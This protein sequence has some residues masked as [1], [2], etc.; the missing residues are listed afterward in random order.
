MR[1]KETIRLT[2]EDLRGRWYLAVKEATRKIFRDVHIHSPVNFEI[3][4]MTQHGVVCADCGI[5]L[6]WRQ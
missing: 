2:Q 4:G 5:V 6:Q 3:E 1:V